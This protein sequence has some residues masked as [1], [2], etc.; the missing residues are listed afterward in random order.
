MGG[1]LRSQRGAHRRAHGVLGAG[2]LASLALQDA[3]R[4]VPFAAGTVQP[5]FDGRDAEAHRLTGARVPPLPRGELLE[6]GAQR[7]SGRR[8]GQQVSDDREAQLRPAF[9]DP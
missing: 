3:D 1:V 4:I 9:V 5:S 8:R 6:L 7:A 2:V